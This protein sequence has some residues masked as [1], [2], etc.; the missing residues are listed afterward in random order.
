MMPLLV[1]F[2]VWAYT[3]VFAFAALWYAH[4]ALDALAD[5]RLRREMPRRAVESTLEFPPLVDS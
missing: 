2:F 5:L 1:P 4:Y 3:L